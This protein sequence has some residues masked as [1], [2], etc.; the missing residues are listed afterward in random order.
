M[1]AKRSTRIVRHDEEK[2]QFW[3]TL[4]L[5]HDHERV[6]MTSGVEVVSRRISSVFSRTSRRNLS[7]K[8]S[9]DGWWYGLDG[10][11]GDE[12]DHDGCGCECDLIIWG[13]QVCWFCQCII[14]GRWF[15]SATSAWWR[16]FSSQTFSESVTLSVRRKRRWFLNR[17]ESVPPRPGP[18][19]TS[20]LATP[21]KWICSPRCV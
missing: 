6:K 1:D 13:L 20:A 17:S 4:T 18:I 11:V 12:F 21:P 19:L 3:A 14:P 2:Y 8:Q 9:V 15:L 5:H 16:K 7:E 10:M